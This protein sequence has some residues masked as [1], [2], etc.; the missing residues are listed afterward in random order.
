LPSS[1]QETVR[2]RKNAIGMVKR[3]YRA[4]KI[5]VVNARPPGG[6]IDVSPSW[7][8]VNLYVDPVFTK[9]DITDNLVLGIILGYKKRRL[10]RGLAEAIAILSLAFI[11]SFS[12]SVTGPYYTILYL[13]VLIASALI[14]G[15]IVIL[16]HKSAGSKV[17][18]GSWVSIVL[19]D[20]ICH[21]A[22]SSIKELLLWAIEE[23]DR[24][25]RSNE[26]ARGKLRW[27]RRI[28]LY[29]RYR[30][31]IKGY[32]ALLVAVGVTGFH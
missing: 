25:V 14:A 29:N 11:G 28:V 27:P 2:C 18:Q 16:S 20:H 21:A 22:V 19:S 30:D 23:R 1:M 32:P 9:N 3:L 13:V 7:R 6:K 17:L 15:Y 10:V 26:F 5:V 31:I 4:R 12:K 24:E 8:T